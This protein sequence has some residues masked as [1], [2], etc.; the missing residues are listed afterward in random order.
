MRFRCRSAIVLAS[1]RPFLLN[2]AFLE[3]CYRLRK[4]EWY[5][6]CPSEFCFA[7][8]ISFSVCI[9]VPKP[10]VPGETIASFFLER[11]FGQSKL[12]LENTV[13]GPSVRGQ[14]CQ[15]SHLVSFW[16]IFQRPKKPPPPSAPVIKQGAGNI[17]FSS[18]YIICVFLCIYL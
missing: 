13:C 12:H 9:K 2:C 14:A 1:F 4:G 6:V 15:Q 18:I 3:G 7:D 11:F 10:D 8:R 17:P 16:L 5:F